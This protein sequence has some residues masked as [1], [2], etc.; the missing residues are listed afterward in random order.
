MENLF[1]GGLGLMLW[2]EPLPIC[3][4]NLGLMDSFA[5]NERV[6]QSFCLLLSTWP[7]PHPSFSCVPRFNERFK[8]A[9]AYEIMSQACEFYVQTFFDQFGHAPLLPH[10]FP[11]DY[12]DSIM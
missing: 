1:P 11:L 3:A 2:S 9:Q 7:D 6:L 10:Q 8:Q 5:D 4:G 12:H